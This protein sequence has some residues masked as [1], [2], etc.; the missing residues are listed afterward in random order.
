M[1]LVEFQVK[2]QI[3]P[4]EQICSD[5]LLLLSLSDSLNVNY[6][7]HTSTLTRND[8]LIINPKVRYSIHGQPAEYLEFRI[9]SRQFRTLFPQKKYVFFCDSSQGPNDNYDLLR[10]YLTEFVST[11]YGE[12]EYQ[13]A[14][15]RQ[16]SYQLLIFLVNNFAVANLY[17]SYS[18]R[19]E[20]ILDY[21]EQNYSCDLALEQISAHFHLTAQ[22]FSK[23]FKFN[24][25]M[26]YYKYL[27]HIRLERAVEALLQSDD[28]LIHIALEHGFPNAEAFH[29][30]FK[31][32]FQVTPQEYR[33]LHRTN[34][35]QTTPDKQALLQSLP[36][37]LDIKTDVQA[38]SQY[39]LDVDASQY[40]PYSC[41]WN[42][43]LNLGAYNT[44]LDQQVHNQLHQIQSDLRFTYIRIQLDPSQFSA[45]EHYSFYHEEYL[46]DALL[47][48]RFGIWFY[49]DV[50][51]LHNPERLYA[52]LDALLSHFANRYSIKNI[53]KWRFELVYN[54]IY[55]DAKC[56]R[57]WTIYD[58][59]Q[60]I[61]NKY[62]CEMPLMG[63]GIALGNTQGLRVFYADLARRNRA[64]PIQ[65]FQAEPYSC[66]S[67][68]NGIFLNR[69]TDSGYIKNKLIVLQH[70]ISNFPQDIDQIYITSGTDM[71]LQRNF[72]NDSCYR[73]A[74]ILKTM[75]DC[76]ETVKV[77][78]YSKPLDFSDPS[79]L[80]T[81]ELFGGEGLLTKHGLKKP[82]FYA[83]QF[84]NHMDRF[85][86]GRSEHAIVFTNG[87]GNYQILCHNCKALNYKYYLDERQTEQRPVS[88][89][90][91][92]ND[93]IQLDFCL[94]NVKNGRYII[95]KRSISETQGNLQYLW[96]Q[97]TAD[98]H[99]YI[100]ANDLEYLRGI[101]IPHLS[102]QEYTASD[103]QIRLSEKLSS[104]EFA[105]IHI[106]LEY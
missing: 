8:V 15:R 79:A 45:Q 91:L 75:I 27:N 63:A 100:H 2:K 53:M 10:K 48:L 94:H 40:R 44:T 38:Q 68:K 96:N 18:S 5:L 33:R 71:T 6:D 25:G 59:I 41:H 52:Y 37:I 22:Y 80:Q 35:T 72:I 54:T 21:I 49:A 81:D 103:N 31:S 26:T 43:L 101:A 16:K 61:L 14:E 47:D 90:F 76:F 39:C 69:E 92:D 70:N 9:D 55:D 98:Q 97:M 65:T 102:L 4:E 82:S 34:H 28:T 58:R 42:T 85:F 95:K 57:Y 66:I 3:V 60:H 29:R 19:T 23:Y 105:Y 86:V 13:L 104:N 46:F 20:E 73:G 99:V 83:Y 106:I 56:Q 64:L 87:N 1:E 7:T 24:T 36:H 78:S 11:Y 62:Q 51:F 89:Y 88:E 74:S 67:T 17:A 12:Y 50:H 93:D 84:L 32:E 30:C 77:L